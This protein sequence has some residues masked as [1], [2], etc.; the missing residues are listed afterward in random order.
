MLATL[1]A[2][3][4]PTTLQKIR[5]NHVPVQVVKNVAYLEVLVG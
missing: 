3:P 2:I 5:A 1:V 4:T